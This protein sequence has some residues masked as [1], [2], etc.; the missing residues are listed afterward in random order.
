MSDRE[1]NH[2]PLL[3]VIIVGVAIG[4]LLSTLITAKWIEYQAQVAIAEATTVIQAQKSQAK[5]EATAST[6]RKALLNAQQQEAM[7]KQRASDPHGIRLH[8][9]CEEWKTTD[10]SLHSETTQAE[11]AIHCAQYESYIQ[12]GVLAS[13]K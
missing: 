4:N 11:T 5:T 2:F 1:P 3:I 9:A 13:V 6:Q 12:T 8:Q 7:R 10:A